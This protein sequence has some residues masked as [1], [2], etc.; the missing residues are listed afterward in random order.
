MSQVYQLLLGGGQRGKPHAANGLRSFYGP[1][2]VVA[3]RLQRSANG[4]DASRYAPV[5]SNDGRSIVTASIRP[6]VTWRAWALACV[7][8]LLAGA[9]GFAQPSVSHGKLDRAVNAA[10]QESRA[11]G[12]ILRALPGREHEVRAALKARH[13]KVTDDRSLVAELSPDD[14]DFVAGLDAVAGVSADTVVRAAGAGTTKTAKSATTNSTTSTAAQAFFADYSASTAQWYALMGSLGIQFS[15][16]TGAGVGVAVVDSGIDGTAAQFEGRISAFYDFTTRAGR[17]GKASTPIDDYGHGTHVAGLIGASS[18]TFGGIAPKV[19]FVGIKVLDATGAGT[20]SNLIK[21][22]EFLTTNKRA[23]NI[24]VINLS[25]G[26]PILEPAGTDPLVQAVE[27]AVAAGLV[28]V[29]SAGNYGQNPS[30]GESGY[31]GITSPGNAPSAIT[32]GSLD[33]HG[34]AD[35]SDDT[36]SPFSSR[37]PTWYDGFAKPDVLAPGHGLYS[38]SAEGSTL[39][40]TSTVSISGEAVKLYGTSMAAAT[41]TGLVALLLEANRVAFPA[42]GRDLPPNALKAMLQ[43]SAV[44]VNDLDKS[45]ELD[46]LTQ[47]AGG[48]NGAGALSL[49]RSLD[50]S[51]ALG[52]W[53]LTMPVIE[54]STLGGVTLPWSRRIIWGQ[55]ALYGDAIYTNVPAWQSN[56]VWGNTLVWG[57]SL[58]WGDTLNRTG[59]VGGLF[60]REDGAHGPTEQVSRRVPRARRTPRARA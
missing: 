16:R 33:V 32:A 38:T 21:A 17:S 56:I 18:L 7:A 11:V 25:L 8:V 19:H 50:P 42:A 1:S 10:R 15:G 52:T 54:S 36:A 40:R 55:S 14:I 47:G 53:W 49:A 27:N 35:R 46:L 57:E 24:H 3:A 9:T 29:A 6:H 34:T 31:A 30:T 2:A 45:R 43:F 4:C 12:V 37:G 51:R 41:T 44:A 39:A 48:L 13:V 26:H 60:Q 59:F 23:L 20:T 22:I 58:I 5:N 28:V